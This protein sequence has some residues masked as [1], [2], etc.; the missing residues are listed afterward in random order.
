MYWDPNREKEAGSGQKG[1]LG[2]LRGH[3]IGYGC[4]LWG[5]KLY[6]WEHW[7]ISTVLGVRTKIDQKGLNS[8]FGFY[9]LRVVIPFE[10]KVVKVKKLN[11]CHVLAHGVLGIF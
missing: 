5:F 10:E 6:L 4:F 7:A 11:S 2:Q 3:A 1:W 9:F 8:V